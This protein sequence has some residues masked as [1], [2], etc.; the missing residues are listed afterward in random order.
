MRVS[1]FSE[2]QIVHALR[3]A[4]PGRRSSTSAGRWKS[5][6]GQR[7]RPGLPWVPTWRL[8]RFVFFVTTACDHIVD[9]GCLHTSRQRNG[10]SVMR[11]CYRAYQKCCF[12]FGQARRQ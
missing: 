3:Q 11:N 4:E 1:K 10:Y 6:T 12:V 2:E 8:C 7:A 5:P 9:G